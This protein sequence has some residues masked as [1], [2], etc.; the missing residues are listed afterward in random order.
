MRKQ[1]IFV[2][3]VMCLF[4][5]STWADANLTAA[6]KFS[7]LNSL[8]KTMIERLKIEKAELNLISAQLGENEIK[9][10][11]ELFDKYSISSSVK[12]E[13]EFDLIQFTTV[14]RTELGIE[15]QKK[16]SQVTLNAI[17]L[18][19]RELYM[20]VFSAKQN[21]VLKTAKRDLSL[22]KLENEKSKRKAGVSLAF[23]LDSSTL[24]L[25]K[26]QQELA[27]AKGQYARLYGQL[28]QMTGVDVEI[29][30]QKLNQSSVS[31]IDTYVLG[32]D[33]RMEI[34]ANVIQNQ[35]ASLALPYYEKKN[36]LAYPDLKK[37]YD[38]IKREIAYRET[39]IKMDRLTIRQEL[40]RAI[41]DIKVAKNQIESLKSQKVQLTKRAHDLKVMA[42]KGLVSS[43][44]VKELEVG[45]LELDH[46]LNMAIMNYNLKRIKL[47]YATSIGPAYK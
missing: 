39:M 13:L 30:A 11:R 32:I 2:L 17:G 7:D 1:F 5:A 18:G 44:Q 29:S 21:I 40:E 36:V 23:T 31:T 37:N 19:A 26:A 46:G 14:K 22:Q 16:T 4:S 12:E 25:K 10:T 3:L 43:I 20:G 47:N 45:I 27:L 33:N 38:D 15:L 41:V 35:M 34:Q 6:M 28:K 42:A 8:N 24:D 9:G